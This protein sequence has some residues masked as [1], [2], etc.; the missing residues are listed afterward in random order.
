LPWDAKA[1][2]QREDPVSILLF[3]SVWPHSQ[4]QSYKYGWDKF[5]FMANPLWQTL[6]QGL[7]S[8]S[9]FCPQPYEGKVPLFR[10]QR[11]PPLRSHPVV[12]LQIFVE[13]RRD[14]V[15]GGLKNWAVKVDCIQSP[16]V[17]MVN[18]VRVTNQMW[19]QPH[20]ALALNLEHTSSSHLPTIILHV[21]S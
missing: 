9:F 3:N 20:W 12:S 18:R 8:D 16:R 15:S 5:C 7:L 10:A 21:C 13:T 4:D 19:L 2:G 14:V 11:V 1:P 17:F 6:S